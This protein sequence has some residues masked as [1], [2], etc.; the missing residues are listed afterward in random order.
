MIFFLFL[1][2]QHTLIQFLEIEP[3]YLIALGE[4]QNKKENP[5]F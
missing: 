4:L 5:I 3:K 1:T 2:R